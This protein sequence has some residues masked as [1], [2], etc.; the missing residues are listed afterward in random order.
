MNLCP[1]YKHPVI[2]P[3]FFPVNANSVLS[4]PVVS[5]LETQQESFAIRNSLSRFVTLLSSSILHLLPIKVCALWLQGVYLA[6][7]DQQYINPYAGSQ[8]DDMT[9]GFDP[10]AIVTAAVLLARALDTLALGPSHAPELQPLTV[11]V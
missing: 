2:N 4:T 7:F 10:R 1:P 3:S 5:H 11:G 6:E 8:F 9:H